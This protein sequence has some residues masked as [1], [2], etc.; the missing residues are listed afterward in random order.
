MTTAASS[1][2][3][4]SIPIVRHFA[5]LTVHSPS[6]RSHTPIELYRLDNWKPTNISHTWNGAVQ[7]EMAE[8]N[9]ARN[10][11]K[12]EYGKFTTDV[13]RRRYNFHHFDASWTSVHD[14]GVIVAQNDGAVIFH[15]HALNACGLHRLPCCGVRCGRWCRWQQRRSIQMMWLH[16]RWR[17]CRWHWRALVA[18]LQLD[19]TWNRHRKTFDQL[20]SKGFQRFHNL[21]A[22]RF[23]ASKNLT[24]N[25]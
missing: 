7:W 23:L 5:R 22:V 12:C 18:R 14:F 9:S 13:V 16:F 20:D 2:A 25:H 24:K 11:S 6:A 21:F 19:S 10:K 8:K 1:I 3:P 15:D 4:P 17:G